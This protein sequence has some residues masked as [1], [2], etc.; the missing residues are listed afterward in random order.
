MSTSHQYKDSLWRGWHGHWPMRIRW[1][2]YHVM[3]RCSLNHLHLDMRSCV[4]SI[5]KLFIFLS[6]FNFCNNIKL[7]GFN[8]QYPAVF[9]KYLNYNNL[10]TFLLLAPYLLL[11]RASI[12]SF[13][14]MTRN[15][16]RVAIESGKGMKVKVVKLC[17]NKWNGPFLCI[18]MTN[19]VESC[20]KINGRVQTFRFSVFTMGRQ[21]LCAENAK[22][23]PKLEKLKRKLLNF[24]KRYDL[25]RVV[26]WESWRPENSENVVVFETNKIIKK[27]RWR[28]PREINIQFLRTRGNNEH[29]NS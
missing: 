21:E 8:I 2:W 5:C 14:L 18:S 16:M 10:L 7:K 26:P 28:R 17:W 3:I 25:Y 19:N 29:G 4:L 1:S 20:K 6:S 12:P 15:K 23:T 27:S 13:P 24:L 11:K 22:K 9:A